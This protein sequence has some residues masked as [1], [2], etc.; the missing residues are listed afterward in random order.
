MSSKE[1]VHLVGQPECKF[2]EPMLTSG[3]G[4][5]RCFFSASV[6]FDWTDVDHHVLQ[7]HQYMRTRLVARVIA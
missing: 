5:G 3:I 2:L 1:N 6:I 7:V 4:A